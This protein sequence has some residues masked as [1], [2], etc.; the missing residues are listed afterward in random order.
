MK[1][2]KVALVDDHTLVREGFKILL[3]SHPDFEV[4]MESRNGDVALE[5]V[6]GKEIDVIVTDISMP[7]I[8]GIDLCYRLKENDIHIPVVML[9]M[10][11]NKEYLVNAFKAGA[12]GYLVKDC[13]KEEL[14]FALKKI[15]KGGTY[16]GE[17]LSFSM[18]ETI[19]AKDTQPLSQLDTLTKREKEI[20]NMLLEGFSTKK[21]ADKLFISYRTVDKHRSNMMEK[22]KV[23]NVV[24]LLNYAQSQS[25]TY[26]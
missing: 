17:A 16:F 18:L 7:N 6:D 21:I 3:N 4:V 9:S 26:N 23:H 15:V 5:E 20:L 10:Y 8:G 13:D 14:F 19:L 22:L 24:D 11:S 2:I 25:F 1:K 12:S